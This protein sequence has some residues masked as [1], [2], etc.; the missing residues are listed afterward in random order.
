MKSKILPAITA[1][2]RKETV[3][4]AAALLAAA[5]VFVIP[6]DR[7]YLSYIDLRTLGLLFSLM[8][9][10]SGVKR[11]GVFSAL[12]YSLTSRTKSIRGLVTV[13]VLAAFFLSMLITND[14]ALITLVPLTLTCLRPDQDLQQPFQKAPDH[15]AGQWLIPAV[16]LETIAANLGSMTTP[17]GNPQNLY[18]YRLAGLSLPA[19]FRLILPYSMLSLILLLLWILLCGKRASS[20]R[21]AGPAMPKPAPVTEYRVLAVY[22]VLFLFCLLTVA[23]ILPWQ[24]AFAA[25]LLFALLFDRRT[26]EGVDYSLLGT[27]ALL[28]IFI[29]NIGRIDAFR[30]ALTGILS[31]HEVITAAAASQV[32]SN[33][34][35]AI[36]LSGFTNRIDLLIIGTNIGGLGTLIASMAS[37]ISYRIM[38]KEY[39]A[40]KGRYIRSFTFANL[41]FLAILL[42]FQM[43]LRTA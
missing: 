32:M 10:V 28:F 9:V 43:L 21:L 20:G 35:A 25:V 15:P 36:L 3:L 5:S 12:A 34:P 31:G 41:V 18:L 4:S 14:V 2:I 26:L 30:Q 29:G 16:V 33:V 19:F 22:S 1:F 13:L 24:A 37:L 23:R 39:P 17:V 11:R 38:V 42:G 40:V 27:F 8:T 7:G 6:P